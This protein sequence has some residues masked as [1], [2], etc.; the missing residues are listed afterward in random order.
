L[1][2]ASDF[3]HLP[4]C[5]LQKNIKK[6]LRVHLEVTNGLTRLLFATGFMM[7]SESGDRNEDV[8]AVQ[9]MD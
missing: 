1:P 7:S 5:T 6:G 2:Y 4:N 3:I 8:F 9:N